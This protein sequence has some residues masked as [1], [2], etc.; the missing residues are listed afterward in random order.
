MS[1]IRHFRALCWKNWLLWRRRYISSICELAFPIFL[2]LII[3][4][5]RG[6][7]KN[8]EYEPGSNFDLEQST[9]HFTNNQSP[10]SAALLL[11]TNSSTPLFLCA[12][13]HN[14]RAIWGPPT[15]RK[16]VIAY[17]DSKTT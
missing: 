12:L 5:I 14:I 1:A 8:K 4:M 10:S 15:E 16:E 13:T 6:L 3:V 2:M 11:Q 7:A 9:V 17:I